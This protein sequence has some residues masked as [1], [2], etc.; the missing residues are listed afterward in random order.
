MR[1]DRRTE[2]TGMVTDEVL[3]PASHA[4]NCGWATQG[5]HPTART[6]EGATANPPEP[7]RPHPNKTV[8]GVLGSE[9]SWGV[10]GSEGYQQA[11]STEDRR[12]PARYWC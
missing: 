5:H 4:P 2:T 1:Y 10:L 11:G 3:P 7:V 8:L 12:P 6:P 9:G